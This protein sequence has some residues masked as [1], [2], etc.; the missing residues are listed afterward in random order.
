MDKA[1]NELMTTD[2]PEDGLSIFDKEPTGGFEIQ[3]RGYDKVQVEQHIRN[4][5]SAIATLR[6][7][8]V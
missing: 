2:V 3:L 5:A 1:Q 4:M 7:K 8:N 6:N